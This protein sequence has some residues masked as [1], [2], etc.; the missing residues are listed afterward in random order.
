[1]S[2]PSVPTWHGSGPADMV[3]I[4]PGVSL[5]LILAFPIGAKVRVLSCPYSE[6]RPGWIGVVESY[7][8]DGIRVQYSEVLLRIMFPHEIELITEKE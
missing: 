6:V 8:L 1:M 5:D 3:E 4:E 7:I 2:N